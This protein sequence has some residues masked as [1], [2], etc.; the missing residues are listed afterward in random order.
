MTMDEAFATLGGST[1]AITSLWFQSG[2]P[3]ID[4]TL[5]LGTPVPLKGIT[6]KA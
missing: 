3:V 1:G 4:R 2:H 6:R 5:G